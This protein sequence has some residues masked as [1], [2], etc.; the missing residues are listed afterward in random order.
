[1]EIQVFFGNIIVEKD[2]WNP[3]FALVYSLLEKS[4]KLHQFSGYVAPLSMK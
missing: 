1:M 2:A 4:L 3:F